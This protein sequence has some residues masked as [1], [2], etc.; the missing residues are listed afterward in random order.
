MSVLL[1]TR[2]TIGGDLNLL[3][4]IIILILL[5]IGYKFGKSK[6]ASSLK[7]H[8]RMMTI[9]VLLN[10]AS[11]LL[12]MGPSF[13]SAFSNVLAEP[14]NIGFPLTSLHHSLGLIAEILGV[15]L[16]FKKFGNVRMWMRLTMSFWLVSLALGIIL[17][18]FYFVI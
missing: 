13:F 14:A 10:A 16:V 7:T 15:I 6:T 17:Y 18:V 5:L 3:I 1:G 12:V 2:A 9:V 4:Q 11:I 8:G